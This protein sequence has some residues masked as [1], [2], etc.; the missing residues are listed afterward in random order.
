VTRIVWE[1][2]EGRC[3]YIS[4][5]GHRCEESRR[6]VPHHLDPWVLAGSPDDPAAYELRCQ[7][8]NDYEGRLYFG[9]RRRGDDEVR[10]R[11][12]PYGAGSF[13]TESVP[14]QTTTCE[15]LRAAGTIQY[16]RRAVPRGSRDRPPAS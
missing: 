2:D 8:H 3:K 7:R 9:K 11:P 12:A 16:A 1:R 14:E 5:D 6:V 4:P 13:I 10:E 15:P